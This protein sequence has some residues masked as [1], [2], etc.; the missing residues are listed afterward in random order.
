MLRNAEVAW[1]WV[2]LVIAVE[3][4]AEIA[5]VLVILA[6]ISMAVQVAGSGGGVTLRYW[7]PDIAGSASGRPVTTGTPAG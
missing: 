1:R 2:L 6:G 4:A 5:G 3:E 7:S